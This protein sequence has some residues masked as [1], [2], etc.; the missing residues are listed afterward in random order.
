MSRY[1]NINAHIIGR[2]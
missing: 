2:R 1:D